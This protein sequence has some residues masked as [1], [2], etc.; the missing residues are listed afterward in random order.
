[1][2]TELDYLF[3]PKHDTHERRSTMT[4]SRAA[5]VYVHRVP[6]IDEDAVYV[7]A[8]TSN[9]VESIQAS[10]IPFQEIY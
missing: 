8:C 7:S 9:P 5:E 4:G 3:T 10:L 1:M 6:Q 2:S